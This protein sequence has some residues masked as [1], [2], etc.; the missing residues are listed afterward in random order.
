MSMIWGLFLT[1]MFC[2]LFVLIV[3]GIDK[4]RQKHKHIH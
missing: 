4:Y 2:A 1:L 3:W